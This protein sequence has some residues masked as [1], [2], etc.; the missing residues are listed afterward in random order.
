MRRF[1]LLLVLFLPTGLC[2]GQA[3]IAG[4]AGAGS[5][6]L[7]GADAPL[8]NPANLASDDGLR[9]R[10][11]D[12]F[13]ALSNSS[14]SVSDYRT[15]NGADLSE[16]DE[17][18]LL[19]KIDGDGFE[20]R[21]ALSANGFAYRHSSWAIG[22]RVMGDAGTK[23]PKDA[24]RLL[25]DGNSPDET[26]AFDTADGVGELIGE[27]R[28][29]HGRGVEL[30][31]VGEV[32]LGAS[33]KWFRGWYY[34]GIE[35]AS[36]M[37]HTKVTGVDAEGDVIFRTA[38]GGK[39][40]GFD[41][42][43]SKEIGDSWSMSIAATNI[44]SRVRWTRSTK[45]TIAHVSI[46]EMTLQ[47]LDDDDDPVDTEDETYSIGS[48]RTSIPTLLT[49]GTAHHRGRW[50][51]VADWQQGFHESL[52]STRTPRVA[53]GA[54]MQARGWIFGRAGFS[55]GGLDRRSLAL[56]LGLTPG[57]VH[58]DFVLTA[59]NGLFPFTGKGLGAGFG[60]GL[61]F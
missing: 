57:I 4:L 18:K 7:S 49:L 22:M 9:L 51:F 28:L 37:L 2:F 39:G 6:V 20:A 34:A 1:L 26:F 17:D 54:E 43:A 53:I 11:L 24:L 61:D 60:L 16:E 42:G 48:F 10:L 35:E 14:Y 38:T 45:E 50:T 3:R 21:G 44:L 52:R 31:H 40:F 32:S 12:T 25:F 23:M 36:G 41:L 5:A 59:S 8:M 15:Y 33:L 27:V 19:A 46:E 30:P 47:N 58:L 56:G 55:A 29:S 13:G